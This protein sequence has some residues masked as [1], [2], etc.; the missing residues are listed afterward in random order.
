MEGN[1]KIN[2]KKVKKLLSRQKNV[3]PKKAAMPKSFNPFMAK[4]VCNLI[5]VMTRIKKIIKM[6]LKIHKMHR[7]VRDQMSV[8][9]LSGQKPTKS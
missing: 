1:K 5:I 2:K 9:I 4:A 8:P 6:K 3:Q 7:S